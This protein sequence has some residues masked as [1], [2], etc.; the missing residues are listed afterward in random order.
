M[1]SSLC[2][3][4]GN[5]KQPGKLKA[6]KW[7]SRRKYGVAINGGSWLHAARKLKAGRQ[8]G[9]YQYRENESDSRQILKMTPTSWRSGE[10]SV[11]K[12]SKP[13]SGLAVQ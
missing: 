8:S 13:E 2:R 12:L 3:K 9:Q 4:S 10:E 5:E 7:L 6:A 1:A 11:A